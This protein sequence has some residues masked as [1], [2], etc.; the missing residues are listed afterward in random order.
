MPQMGKHYVALVTTLIFTALNSFATHNRAGEITYRHVSGFT[1][2]F[3]ITTCT[4][5]SAIADREWLYIRFGD[6]SNTTEVDSIQRDLID[7]QA[8]MDA[9]INKYIGYHTYSGPGIFTIVVEDPNRNSGVLNIDSG[10]SVDE[11][12]CIKSVLVINPQTGH[13][14][15]VQLLNPPKEMACYLQPWIHNPAASDPDGDQLVY[16]LIPCMGAGCEIVNGYEFPD[17]NTPEADTFTIDPVSGDVTWLV[18]TV[19]GEFNIAILIEEYRD[20]IFVGSVV[21]DMQITVQI[22][23]NQP[24][25]LNNIADICV[26]AGNSVSIDANAS[27]PDGDPID[28]MAFGLPLSSTVNQATFNAMNGEFDWTPECEEV[29]L[30]P[31]LVT[32]EATDDD[33]TVSLTDV[34]SVF[35]TV[36]APE[37]ENP[38]ADPS[39]NSIVLNWD[40]SP[41][42]GIFN[43]FEAQQV[44]YKIYRRQN[45]YG[46]VPGPCEIGVP[47]YTGYVYLDEV[48]GVNTTTYT[49]NSI[50]YGGNYCYMVV[51]CWPD[52]SVSFASEEFCAEIIKEVPIMTKVSIGVT[53][54]FA[55]VDTVHWSPPTEL[56][57]ETFPGPYQYRLYHADGFGTPT[58]LIFTSSTGPDIFTLADTTFI[59]QNINTRDNAHNYHVEFYFTD[60]TT[61]ELTRA[62]TSSKASSVFLVA[63]PDDNSVTL[64]FSHQTPWVNNT[65]DVYRFDS[66]IGDFVE[67]GTSVTDSFTDTGLLNNVAY[68]YKAIAHGT[69]NADEAYLNNLINHSQ[70]VCATPYDRTPPCPPLLTVEPDCDDEF[71]LLQWVNEG[72]FC[73]NDVTGY[74]LYYAPVEGQALSLFATFDLVTNT[75]YVFNEEGEFNTIAGCFAVTALDSLNLWPDGLLHQNE[76]GFSDVICVDN[77]PLYFLPNIMTPNADGFNDLFKPFDYRYIESIDIKI[78]DRW[79]VLVF[80]STD[81]EINWN[82]TSVESGELCSDGVYYYTIQVNTIRLSGIVPEYFSGTIQMHNARGVIRGE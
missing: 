2:E 19:I 37:V 39:G 76:S 60:E 55:G 50:A 23:N 54:E 77:C 12:F 30:N 13:N 3:T 52:G 58:D 67:I 36:L 9:Q 17:V 8:G 48:T 28:Y 38:V 11:V 81:P 68:C 43:S 71:D 63:I 47:A 41:C 7:P 65:Y 4:K 15:S 6:E 16:S 64:Q 79:G 66:G 56:D 62:N 31:Y 82:G 33:V 32:F 22:C 74:N 45:Q 5:S 70:E 61:G 46:F 57:T 78:L 27:D 42:A 72:G 75:T 1:Y 29:R 40:P 69:Y 35:I 25:V 24:P 18:P 51:T 53:D 73:P 10:S 80:E 26:K 14:N 20:G 21:R 49:D 44:S 34:E 59:H